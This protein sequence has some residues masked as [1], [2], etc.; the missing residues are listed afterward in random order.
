[1]MISGDIRGLGRNIRVVYAGSAN[2]D[3]AA[4]THTDDRMQ[5]YVERENHDD[6]FRSYANNFV[7]L[8][9]VGRHQHAGGRCLRGTD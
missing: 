3:D 7:R 1:M 5:R 6:V 4:L 2:L 9:A 8:L